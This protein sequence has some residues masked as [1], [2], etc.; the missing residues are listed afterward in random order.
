MVGVVAEAAFGAVIVLLLLRRAW[1]EPASGAL[2][3][4]PFG[5]L[6]TIPAICP[7]YVGWV[8]GVAALRDD[9]RFNFV[10]G[11]A[12]FVAPIWYF[13]WLHLIRPPAPV[14]AAV[15]L[16]TWGSVVLAVVASGRHGVGQTSRPRILELDGYT[17]TSQEP[18]ELRL[19]P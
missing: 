18:V 10:A 1:S 5:A 13:G 6:A 11:V 7:H 19:S 8:A 15:I 3:W 14:F 9:S 17:T 16:V 4:L 12:T 2:A